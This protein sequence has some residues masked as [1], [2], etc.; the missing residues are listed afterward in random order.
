M[1]RGEAAFSKDRDRDYRVFMS[2][3]TTLRVTNGEVINNIDSV[4]TKIRSVV[5]CLQIPTTQR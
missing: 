4:L 2:G 1:H 3:Y 5:K